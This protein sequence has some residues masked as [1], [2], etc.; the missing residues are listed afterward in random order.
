MARNGR[1]TRLVLGMICLSPLAMA[2]NLVVNPGFETAGSF[3]P[4]VASNYGGNGGARWVVSSTP[5][6]AHSGTHFASTGCNGSLGATCI[7]PDPGAGAWLYQ[8]LTTVPGA[9]YTLTFY[10]A[11]GSSVGGGAAELQVLWGPSTTPLTTGG[12]GSCTGNCVFDNT[13]IGSSAYTQYTVGLTATASTMRLEFL[14]RQDPQVDFLDDISV[15]PPVAVPTLGPLSLLLLMIGLACVGSYLA[16]RTR[17]RPS[18]PE[19][20]S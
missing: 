19:T 14:G 17:I 5:G 15:T 4:W 9:S 3:A 10:Y 7:A 11:P 12:N 6:G 16:R 1:S 20:M 18:A 13:G 8:D 2:Q